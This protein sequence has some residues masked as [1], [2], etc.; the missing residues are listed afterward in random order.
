MENHL[1]FHW[2]F[3]FKRSIFHSH[4]YQRPNLNLHFAPALWEG[5]VDLLFTAVQETTLVFSLSFTARKAAD[6]STLICEEK[7]RYHP[8]P[9]AGVAMWK[10]RA[11]KIVPLSQKPPGINGVLMQLSASKAINPTAGSK[12]LWN[13]F[14]R[15]VS[16]F[17]GWEFTSRYPSVD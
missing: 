10:P 3:I 17:W 2:K 9:P 12:K 5:Q 16:V 13:K 6:L 8:D 11:V 7:A 4:V 1:F 15:R 14:T